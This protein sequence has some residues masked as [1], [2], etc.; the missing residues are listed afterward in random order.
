MLLDGEAIRGAIVE[1]LEGIVTGVRGLEPGEASGDLHEGATDE[2]K[3]ARALIRPHFYVGISE[4]RFA[5]GS[6]MGPSS[7]NIIEATIYVRC[8]YNLQGD[9]VNHVDYEDRKAE[10]EVQAIKFA[11]RLMWPG[12]LTTCVSLGRN[13]NILSG[14][15]TPRDNFYRVTRDDPK[16]TLFEVEQ[17]YTAIVRVTAATS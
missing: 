11:Q 6:P 17:N 10:A 12:A 15:L 5:E 1:N 2:M 8:V 4:M 14:C 3:A 16:E 7:L 13:T 9:G